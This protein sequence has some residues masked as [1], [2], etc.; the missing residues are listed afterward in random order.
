MLS[1]PPSKVASWHQSQTTLLL[2]K[3]QLSRLCPSQPCRHVKAQP[4]ELHAVS[5]TTMLALH[6]AEVKHQLRHPENI[7][8]EKAM[9]S[10]C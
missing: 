9:C 4:T 7:A 6:D 1:L 10:L 5:A 8:R 2:M 3:Q